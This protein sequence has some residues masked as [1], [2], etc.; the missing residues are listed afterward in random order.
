MRGIVKGNHFR[1]ITTKDEVFFDFDW[2]T[3]ADYEFYDWN[4]NILEGIKSSGPLILKWSYQMMIMKN[5]TFLNNI[6]SG[7]FSFFHFT[8]N[9]PSEGLA[10]LDSRFE[11]NS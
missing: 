7:D 9:S 3:F 2:A 10:F 5:F 6:G 11:G 4:N 1:N 8:H